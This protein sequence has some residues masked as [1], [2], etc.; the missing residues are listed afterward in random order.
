MTPTAMAF[1]P[2]GRL[3][4]CEQTGDLRV[5]Q[6]DGTLE[7]TPFVHLE[8]DSEGERGLLGIAFDPE[9]VNNQY[10]YV[11]Y[12]V[13]GTPPHNRVSRFTADGDMA[14]PDSQVNILE[15][16]DLSEASN[17]NGGA[18]HF[19]LDEKLYIGVG[20]NAYPPNAQDPSNLLGKILRIN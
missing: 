13:P 4:V 9:F 10:V 18:I 19:G 17:H 15:I 8:V 2:D 16:D 7:P 5:V 1:A 6:S 14:I 3:F 11:Y 20:E 12:T